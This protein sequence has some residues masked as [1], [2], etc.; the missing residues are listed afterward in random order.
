MENE[1]ISCGVKI[2]EKDTFGINKKMLGRNINKYYCMDCLA[3]Y[4]DTSVEDLLEMIEEFR[5]AGC[6]LF[7]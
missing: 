5:E 3:V 1:C 4:L 6:G 2:E 7:V